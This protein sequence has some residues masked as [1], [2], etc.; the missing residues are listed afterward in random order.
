M[1]LL[2]DA[3][4]IVR[5]NRAAYIVI[6]TVYYGL[7]IIFMI[8]AAFNRPLQDMLLKSVGQAFLSGPLSALG[9]AYI[10]AEM[11][12]AIGMTFVVNLVLGTFLYI[13][14]PSAIIPFLGFLLGVFR[15][16]LWG[17]LF[18]PLHPQ[19]RPVIVPA[20]ITILL[21]GQGYILA[22]LAAYVQGRAFLSPKTVRVEG[23]VRGYVEG[24]KLTGKIYILVILTLAVAAICEVLEVVV[25]ANFVH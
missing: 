5:E 25:M 15:A 13:T 11:L 7:V 23:H 24:L 19:I 21:E 10:N 2:K 4:E 18:S 16:S 6:N 14:I 3:W 17:L 22:L 20:I 12:K 1:K 8:V 9:S